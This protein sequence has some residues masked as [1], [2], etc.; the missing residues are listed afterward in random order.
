MPSNL[1]HVPSY[2]RIL[3]AV[4]LGML[5]MINM[6]HSAMASVQCRTLQAVSNRATVA[7]ARAN[8]IHSLEMQRRRYG[9]ASL[10]GKRIRCGNGGHV[11]GMRLH[12]CYARAQACTARGARPMRRYPRRGRWLR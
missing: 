5:A 10:I 2:K 3:P 12:E 9:L 6:T 8:V 7:E 11:N 1:F 4:M